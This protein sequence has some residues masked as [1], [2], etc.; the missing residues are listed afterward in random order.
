MSKRSAKRIDAFNASCFIAAAVLFSYSILS[1]SPS[2][3][4]VGSR[5]MLSSAVVG[6][7]AAVAPNPDN[8]AAAQLQQRAADLDSKAAVIQDL[9]NKATV[10]NSM[11]TVSFFM[12]LALFALVALN[13]VLDWRR[14]RKGNAAAA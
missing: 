3:L 4:A 8:T 7:T 5:T 12:S 2:Q 13:Y 11:A 10:I 1:Q 14:T 6:L 9:E